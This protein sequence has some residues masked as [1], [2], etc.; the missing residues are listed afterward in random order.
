MALLRSFLV[1]YGAL[2]ICRSFSFHSINSPTNDLYPS[3]PC[4]LKLQSTRQNYSQK[5]VVFEA[6]EITV[7]MPFLLLL[8][9]FLEA[10]KETALS[11]GILFGTTFFLPAALMHFVER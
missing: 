8:L 7:L 1:T 5:H 11:R 4:C 2:S 6:I 10:V 3:L 9:P